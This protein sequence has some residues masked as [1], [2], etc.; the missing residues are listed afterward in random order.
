MQ[1]KKG[2]RIFY[3]I[4]ENVNQLNVNDKL[5]AEV[6][7]ISDNDLRLFNASI[8]KFKE[9]KLIFI[10]NYFL[11]KIGKIDN[12]LCSYCK[13]H[14]EKINNLFLTCAKVQE[15]W[16]SLKTWLYEN[17]NIT[18]NI[19]KCNSICSY[20][21]R[22]SLINYIFILAKY[23]I[24]K[25]KFISTDK[26]LDIHAFVAFLKK[27]IISDRYNAYIFNRIANLY[28]YTYIYI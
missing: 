23:Y 14:P 13:E 12:N 20:Q 21:G 15:F 10:T 28:I 3:D 26:N 24:Y 9:V 11:W 1:N 19:E 16:N 25:T 22:N 4:I 6:G 7:D 18:V 2:S 17:T 8:S 5:V 27:K